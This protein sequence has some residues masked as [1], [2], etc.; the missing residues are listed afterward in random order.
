MEGKIT[1][2]HY[3]CL[4]IGL[5]CYYVWL[6]VWLFWPIPKIYSSSQPI[7]RNMLEKT[8]N[9]NHYIFET[10]WN[11]QPAICLWFP[12]K[13]LRT[14]WPFDIVME[15]MSH[16]WMIKYDKHDYSF[17]NLKMAIIQL[18]I[19][20]FLVGLPDLSLLTKSI[21]ISGPSG[22]LSIPI[23][24]RLSSIAGSFIS[25]GGWRNL[26]SDPRRAKKK[27]PWRRGVGYLPPW[28]PWLLVTTPELNGSFNKSSI[29]GRF[30]ITFD[31]R[32]VQA[33]KYVQ[34]I[35]FHMFYV[36]YNMF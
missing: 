13:Y 17:P 5:F 11:H 1:S 21:P 15:A 28:C 6:F 12:K 3:P 8:H 27:G 36:V 4:I 30:S 7:I 16:A 26:R 19:Q 25:R 22:L 14:L 31:Y 18:A 9:N 23:I 10:L 33:V 29:N 24:S 34:N 32:R 35:M 20:E 2:Y